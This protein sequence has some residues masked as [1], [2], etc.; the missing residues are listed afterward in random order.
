VLVL[1]LDGGGNVTVG[2]T[3]GLEVG[4]GLTLGLLLGLPEG[5]EL[6]LVV[7]SLDDV[8][9]A[10]V[11]CVPLAGELVLACVT[12]EDAEDDEQDVVGAG[13]T[14]GLLDPPPPGEGTGVLPWPS[15]TPPPLP[16]FEGLPLV[17]A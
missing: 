2:V 10:A 4:L 13:S 11:V 6:G 16:L 15:G 9:G 12:D 1:G 8:A 14:T 7:L 3:V 17:K 5:L